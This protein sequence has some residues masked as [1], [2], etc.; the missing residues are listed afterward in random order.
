[1][2]DSSQD[3]ENATLN[4]D[5]IKMNFVLD[6]ETDITRD[7]VSFKDNLCLLELHAM[8]KIHNLNLI[9]MEGVPPFF[10]RPNFTKANFMRSPSYLEWRRLVDRLPRDTPN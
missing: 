2:N 7:R 3:E 9:Q 1:M 4:Y 6:R 8:Q 5:E 10:E